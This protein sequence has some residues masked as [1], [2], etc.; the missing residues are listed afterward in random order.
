MITQVPRI[1]ILCDLNGSIIE[2][3]S[4]TLGCPNEGGVGVQVGKL[5]ARLT[6]NGSL[7]KALSFIIEI[8]TR[9]SA[10]DWEFNLAC[11]EEA[12]GLHF[13]GGK[14]DDRLL[15]VGAKSRENMQEYFE[16]MAQMNSEQVNM[17]RAGFKDNQRGYDLFDEISRLNNELTGM[18]RELA[19]K[20]AELERL[21]QEKN[22]F[23]GMAA[24]DLRNPLHA[25]L[26]H[27]EFLLEDY[28]QTLGVQYKEFLEVIFSSSQ[29][30]AH[31]VDDLLDVAKIESGQLVL[32]YSPVDLTG[33]VE[34]AVA[35]NRL[36]SI[37]KQ[38]EI[39]L[40]SESLGTGEVDTA[41][42]EQVLNNLIGNAVKF[43][44]PGK[45]VEVRLY[46]EAENFFLCVKDEGTGITPEVM[47]R[48]FKPFQRGRAR[49]TAGEKSSGLGLMIVKRIV[50]GH[51]GKIWVESQM[52]VGTTFFV[53][54]PFQPVARP[55]GPGDH[56]VLHSDHLNLAN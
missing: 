49:G 54:M 14:I 50:E 40:I 56:Q 31:L 44:H 17:M 2:V 53:R 19:R 43:S 24:H 9:G 4:N 46:G 28:P 23:L 29:Y 30:M 33:L 22:R 21:N 3:I 6:A 51:G 7:A 45:K 15:I 20:N 16:E 32:D 35:L 47:S 55:E 18:Q 38:I 34:N 8:S 25:I 27:S 41:K 37:R 39:T 26:S 13:T 12:L 1:A 11:G 48:L 36:I 10:F 42:F 5:F 52:G